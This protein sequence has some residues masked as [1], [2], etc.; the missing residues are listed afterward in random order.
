[1][2]GEIHQGPYAKEGLEFEVAARLRGFA[3]S[4]GRDKKSKGCLLRMQKSSP[5][6]SRRIG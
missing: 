6:K 5:T 3:D 1:M 4:S 2:M